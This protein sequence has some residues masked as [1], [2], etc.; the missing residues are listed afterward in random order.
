MMFPISFYINRRWPVNLIIKI[1]R[2]NGYD[3]HFDRAR[4]V[5]EKETGK[6]YY[7]I[8]KLKQDAKASMF[9]HMIR[10]N[11]GL[12]VELYSPS[13]S[14]YFPITMNDSEVIVMNEDQKM[15]LADQVYRAHTK[16]AKR[17]WWDKYGTIVLP[18]TLIGIFTFSLVLIMYGANEYALPAMQKLGAQLA[19]VAD[20]LATTTTQ[21]QAASGAIAPPG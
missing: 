12:Y 5:V 19:Q 14:E 11:S 15:F 16:W 1:P 3:L 21:M 17:S 2:K 18:I 4:R 20:K 13:P 6:E 8:R 10:T 7:R 9:K